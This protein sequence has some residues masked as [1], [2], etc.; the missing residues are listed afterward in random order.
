MKKNQGTNEFIKS[1]SYNQD[2]VLKPSSAELS[3]QHVQEVGVEHGL[4]NIL[5]G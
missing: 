4:C 3:G 5:G 2:P 1:V